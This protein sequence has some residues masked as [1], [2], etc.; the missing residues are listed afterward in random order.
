M[1]HDAETAVRKEGII[2]PTDS[3]TVLAA[4]RF[5]VFQ[6]PVKT[7][8]QFHVLDAVPP[9]LRSILV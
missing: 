4:K 9:V 2:V 7:Q 8:T 3:A 5:A 6:E 1:L